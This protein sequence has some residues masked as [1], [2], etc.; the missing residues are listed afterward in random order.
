MSA[1]ASN[2]TAPLT[3]RALAR[4]AAG[5]LDMREG[6][7]MKVYWMMRRNFAAFGAQRSKYDSF[8]WRA[9]HEAIL[10]RAQA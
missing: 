8:R 9:L 6:A 4:R 10:C 3:R 2:C 7:L 1:G 5:R